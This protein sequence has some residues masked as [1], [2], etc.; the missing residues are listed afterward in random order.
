MGRNVFLRK[1]GD[2]L[3]QAEQGGGGITIP[4]GVTEPGDVAMRDTISGHGGGGLSLDLM[5]LDVSSNLNDT[6]VL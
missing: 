1:H 3:A 4:G 6:M 2:E 5:V